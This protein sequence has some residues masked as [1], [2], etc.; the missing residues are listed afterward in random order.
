MDLR[1]QQTVD[2]FLDV[3]IGY[4]QKM[5]LVIQTKINQPAVDWRNPLRTSLCRDH[6]AFAIL[7]SGRS[8]G[9]AGT[10]HGMVAPV[11][12]S[13]TTRTEAFHDA[14]LGRI[15]AQGLRQRSPASQRPLRL[16]CRRG[17]K[18]VPGMVPRKV[19]LG[20]VSRC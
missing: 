14:R 13:S 17:P 4:I 1:Q 15:E 7:G 9:I 11:V 18:V 16:G 5:Q 12:T 8:S 2:V 19:D 6:P 20:H 10:C 3:G